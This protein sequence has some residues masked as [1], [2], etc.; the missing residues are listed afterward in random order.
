MLCQWANSCCGFVGS[1]FGIWEAGGRRGR[2]GEGEGKEKG[3]GRREI[4]LDMCTR[5]GL[6]Q[7]VC[8][9]DGDLEPLVGLF[10]QFWC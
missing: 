1:C 6:G 7:A 9:L 3:R 10:D 4:H 5:T 8:L 2:E